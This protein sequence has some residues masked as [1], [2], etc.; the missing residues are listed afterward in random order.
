M[1]N[2]FNIT[3]YNKDFERLGWIGAPVSQTY[4][5]RF[6]QQSAGEISV[7][8]GSDQDRLLAGSGKRVVVTYKDE[9]LMSG[10]IRALRMEGVGPSASKLTTYQ[11]SDDFRLISRLLLWPNPTQD[12]WDQTSE[13][14]RRTGP[15]ETV[16]RNY[17]A[18]AVD[19]VEE[20]VTVPASL[21]R[22]GS[23]RYN[24]RFVTLAEDLLARLDQSGIGV[25]VRQKDGEPGFD[26]EF[27]E[28]ETW[29]LVLAEEAGT[30]LNSTITLDGPKCTRVVIGGAFDGVDREFYTLENPVLE[31][32]WGDVIEEFVDGGSVSGDYRSAFDDYKRE[33]DALKKVQQARATRLKELR[34][35]KKALSDATKAHARAQVVKDANPTSLKAQSALSKA[36]SAKGLAESQLENA[37][38][39][40]E[41]AGDDVAESTADLR[42]AMTALDDAYEQYRDDILDLGETALAEGR[43]HA[44]FTVEL[45]EGDVFRYGGNG[46]HVGDTVT[47]EVSPGDTR[48]DVLRQCTLSLSMSGG[49]TVT[50]VVGE[51][52]DPIGKLTKLIGSAIKGPN[53]VRTR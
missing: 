50:P 10:P 16:F 39:A 12:I 3:V 6:N 48:T 20:P 32:Q 42:A 2:P 15:I 43:A 40:V 4:H 5:V 26:V 19:R 49:F 45:D 23:V 51:R 41:D 44:G 17:L 47:I 1:D 13:H 46:F 38:Q 11:I 35:A 21:G 33:Y 29:P 37:Q 9:F 7:Q 24:A 34:K 30:L 14:D 18:A 8:A 27:Y 25:R 53:R 28:G 52:S 36:A 22:G 31:E